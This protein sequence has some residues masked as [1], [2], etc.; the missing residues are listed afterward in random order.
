MLFFE[1][2]SIR[3]SSKHIGIPICPDFPK[4][5]VPRAKWN[6]GHGGVSSMKNT[7]AMEP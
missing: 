3:A 1:K 2:R 7:A 6:S 5:H 4:I